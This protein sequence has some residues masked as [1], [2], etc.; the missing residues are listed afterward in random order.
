MGFG[1]ARHDLIV[2]VL[3]LTSGLLIGACGDE[4]EVKG[5]R[6]TIGHSLAAGSPDP[7]FAH[8]GDGSEPA[9]AA[10]VAWLVYTPL[11]TYRHEEGNAGAELIPGLAASLPEVSANGRTYTL[12]LRDG[13]E[14]SDGRQVRVQDFEAAIRRS[15]SLEPALVEQF[16]VIEG[17]DSYLASGRAEADISGIEADRESGEIRIHLEVPDVSFPNVLAMLPATP[18]P[19]AMPVVESSPEPPPGVGP[20]EVVAAS[21]GGRFVLRKSRAFESFDIPDIPTGNVDRITAKPMTTG[22]QQAR[23]V[24]DNRLDYMQETPPAGLKPT[25]FEQA[26]ERYADRPVGSTYYF[27]FDL[28]RPPF[29]DRLVREAINRG[30]DRAALA[31][32]SGGELVPGCSFLA[33]GISGYDKTFDLSGCPYGDPARPPDL[34]RAR[35]MLRR[36]GASGTPVVVWGRADAPFRR[37]TVAYVR[38]LR[39]LGLRPRLRIVDPRAYAAEIARR[40]SRVHTGL[41]THFQTFPHPLDFYRLVD[42]R[43]IQPRVS[44]DPGGIGDPRIDDELDRLRLEPE[45]D[46]VAEDWAA[47]DAYVVS[48]PQSYIAPIGHP[49]LSSFFSERMDVDAAVF[50]PVYLNDYSTFALKEGEL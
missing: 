10:E 41:V 11:L 27:F 43:S 12:T 44:Q 3:A 36:A 1:K 17:V 45:L 33:P 8:P 42:G 31:Q 32:A 21:P 22:R 38:M 39:Q 29:D 15:L 28:R 7:A 25:I 34:D 23:A 5:G 48:P 18:V 37:I 14:Y 26:S 30:I 13:V 19:S 49:K 20:Y 6:I 46:S 16:G 35:R 24:L 40:R 4:E 2:G 47:L 50:H 9:W